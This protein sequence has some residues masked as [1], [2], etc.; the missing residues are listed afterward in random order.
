M[1]GTETNAA[2]LVTTTALIVICLFGWLKQ[3]APG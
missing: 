1:T 3:G 2:H